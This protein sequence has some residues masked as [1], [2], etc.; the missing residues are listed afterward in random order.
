[1]NDNR[2]RKRQCHACGKAFHIRGRSST[3]KHCGSHETFVVELGWDRKSAR[4][5]R[6]RTFEFFVGH[7]V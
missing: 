3:C 5:Q 2:L 6:R 1:M 4:I 7:T